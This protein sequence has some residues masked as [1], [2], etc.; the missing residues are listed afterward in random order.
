MRLS[1]S[2]VALFKDPFPLHA[3]CQNVFYISREAKVRLLNHPLDKIINH[4]GVG[5]TGHLY[6]NIDSTAGE[7]QW[8]RSGVD[9]TAPSKKNRNYK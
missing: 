1:F 9:V 2:D 7:L 6:N 3:T 5:R 8:R 4:D